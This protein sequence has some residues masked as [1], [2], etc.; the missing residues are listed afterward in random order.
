MVIE[1]VLSPMRI[2]SGS[3]MAR[4]SCKGLEDSPSMR[5]I[6]TVRMLCST[7]LR[8]TGYSVMRLAG[9]FETRRWSD[10]IRNFNDLFLDGVLNQLRFIVDVQLAHQVEL[11]C[12][13][14][15][16]AKVEVAGDFFHRIAFGEHLEDFALAGCK[17]GKT[18]Q[19]I[20]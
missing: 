2:S 5:W 19:A 14:G 12:F 7:D 17:S 3:S 16:D 15:F 13:H 1:M 6:G 9:C 20:C 18:R 10:K 11:V 8:I 4:R